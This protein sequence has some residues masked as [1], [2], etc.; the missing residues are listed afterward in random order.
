MLERFDITHFTLLV[1]G[2]VSGHLLFRKL[3]TNKLL[4][5]PPGPPSYPLIGQLLS[6]PQS[7]EER[8]FVSLSAELKCEH[9]L[10]SS[11][12]ALGLTK[13]VRQPISSRL[14]SLALRL[15]S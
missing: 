10:V 11:A 15:S 14:V 8:A 13:S 3:R 1:V 2:V 9:V 12:R 7:S 5:L 6:I 4:P